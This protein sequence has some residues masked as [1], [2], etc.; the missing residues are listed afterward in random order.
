MKPEPAVSN[1]PPARGSDVWCMPLA[2][3]AYLIL[4]LAI[5]SPVLAA[6]R[7]LLP[8][9]RFA[10]EGDRHFLGLGLLDQRAV[11]AMVVR[12][13]ATL[14]SR[15][16]DL[17]GDGQCFPMPRAYTL[18]EHLFAL[19]LLAAIPWALT[20][21]PIL[22]YNATLLLT[23]WIPGLT[24][25]ALARHFTRSAPAAFVA[26][27]LFAL[28]P[29]RIT[30][31]VHPFAH[32]DLW[33]PL[34]LLFLH[35]SCAYGGWRNATALA[36]FVGLVVG[37]SLYP[38]IAA[39]ILLVV[40]GVYQL[41]LRRFRPAATLPQIALAAAMILAV[42]W[43]VLAPYLETRAIW[44]LAQGRSSILLEPR[45]YLPGSAR[46]PG[47]LCVALIV[48]ALVDRARGP[49]RVGGEDPRLV[50]LAA[51][52]LIVW[53]SLGPV[54]IPGIGAVGTPI[55]LLARVVPGLDAVRG[56]PAVGLGAALSFA[57]VAGYGV[58]RLTEGR[59]RRGAIGVVV[60]C[61]AIVLA[62]RFVPL[63]ARP[64]F[65]QD[66]L[67]LTTWVARPDEDAIALVQ[68]VPP[69]A[70]LDVPLPWQGTPRLAM[71]NSLLLDSYSP[72]PTAACYNS[73]VSPVQHQVT[74]LASALPAPAAADALVAL[75]FG[76][77]LFDKQRTLPPQ[78]KA[79][80]DMLR[81]DVEAQR[82]LAPLGRTRR[83]WAY[84]LSSPVPVQRDFGLLAAGD[85]DA[86]TVELPA[87][88][89][90][91]PF[92]FVNRGDA[93]FRHPDPLTP[94]ELVVRWSGGA[95]TGG[96]QRTAS[97]LLPIALATGQ[98][99]TLPITLAAPPGPGPWVVEIARAASPDTVLA[100][101]SV[102][103]LD[104]P[105]RAQ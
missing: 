52:L 10:A 105:S 30:E 66:S 17:R 102:R 16:W 9:S 32:G 60:A 103:V 19:G 25:Y 73:F 99:V 97:A 65:G 2:A 104:A 33:V 39:T 82:R 94:S 80:E 45:A 40:Y 83:F 51:G 12:N 54:T 96:T 100:K 63:L 88:G 89:G 3:A 87:R 48:V 4:A 76:S 67:A 75:G 21:D 14:T 28:T 38:L 37:E 85:A 57:F 95:G 49:R 81:M 13:A 68:K 79:F 98:S 50:L 23:I 15:P 78:H 77:V 42:A 56:L 90:D 44:G 62:T 46:F 29:E 59:S 26:G 11:T 101:R 41:V 34:A 84:A 24:M 31:L 58:L 36:L 86:P 5:L 8:V 71:A 72:R 6:P 53:S 55:L 18:G 22:T 7:T 43:F 64:S 91:V 69:G 47:F 1:E 74:D 61:T 20:H 35:R 70:L 92:V 93:T 27:L